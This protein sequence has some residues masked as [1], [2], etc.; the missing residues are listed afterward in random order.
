MG[1]IKS[2]LIGS[3]L[4][5]MYMFL[6]LGEAKRD[7]LYAVV[8]LCLKSDFVSIFNMLTVLLF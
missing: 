2:I 3:G 1:K 6:A 4:L 5:Y 8:Y 7:I